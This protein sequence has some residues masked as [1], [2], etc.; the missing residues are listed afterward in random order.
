MQSFTGKAEVSPSFSDWVVFKL[1]TLF[2]AE[3]AVQV[4]LSFFNRLVLLPTG[5]LG[6]DPVRV[7]FGNQLRTT[8]VEGQIWVLHPLRLSAPQDSLPHCT[9]SVL[10]LDSKAQKPVT[11]CSSSSCPSAAPSEERAFTLSSH[12][13]WSLLSRVK[14]PPV[15]AC[16]WSLSSAFD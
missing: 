14:S 15:S 16:F 12:A 11:F 8:E 2:W 13:I 6:V 3:A 7:Q 5:C 10:A 1:Q 4:F 9:S